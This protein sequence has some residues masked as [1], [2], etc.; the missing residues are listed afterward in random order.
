[1]NSNINKNYKRART[2]ALVLLFFLGLS[3]LPAAIFMIVDP[4][5]E[6]MQLPLYLL[7]RTPFSNFLIPGIVLGLFNGILSLL[8]A[9]LLIKK[10]PLQS[11]MPIFQGG[12]LLIWL[13]VEILMGIYYPLLTLPYSLVAILLISCGMVMRLSKSGLS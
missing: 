2:I 13:T 8:F 5:G 12:T 7:D 6:S 4:S 9:I 11:I 3:A 10:H 1:M